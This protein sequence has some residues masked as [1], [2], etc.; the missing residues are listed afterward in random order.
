MGA[1]EGEGRRDSKSQ[2]TGTESL[3]LQTVPL[4]FSSKEHP[5]VLLGL[6]ASWLT[7]SF[8]ASGLSTLR[9]PC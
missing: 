3:I 2:S 5:S 6:L 4:D 7:S 8:I 9:L 1:C